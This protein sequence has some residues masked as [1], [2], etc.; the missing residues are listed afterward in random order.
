MFGILEKQNLCSAYL[1]EIRVDLE[2]GKASQRRVADVPN[3]FPTVPDAL[4]GEVPI[5]ATQWTIAALFALCTGSGCDLKRAG[6]A[7]Y[8]SYIYVHCGFASCTFI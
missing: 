5:L 3:E 8:M 2:S 1:S 6:C 7:T 4:V